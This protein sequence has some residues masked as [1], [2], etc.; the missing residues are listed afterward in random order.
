MTRRGT[1]PP[2]THLARSLA[3]TSSAEQQSLRGLETAVENS[4]AEQS[5][6]SLAVEQSVG[7][8]AALP[9]VDQSM[10]TVVGQSAVLPAV[11]QWVE[12]NIVRSVKTVD[13]RSVGRLWWSARLKQLRGSR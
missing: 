8:S 5:V 7:Q 4:A 9:A 6:D 3:K 1:A 10:E 12:A 2:T 13:V 11:K